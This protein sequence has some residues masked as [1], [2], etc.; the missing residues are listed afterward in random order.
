MAMQT[1]TATFT[2]ADD[3]KDVVWP[4]M[5]A[6]F[7]VLVGQPVVTGP[8]PIVPVTVAWAGAPASNG[9]TLVPTAPFDG[10]VEIIVW[11]KP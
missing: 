6:G 1:V 5:P 2:Q 9:G 4:I 7:G 11:D 3:S 10:T 8:T